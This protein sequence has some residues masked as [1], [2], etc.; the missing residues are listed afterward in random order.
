MRFL[1]ERG[2]DVPIIRTFAGG[3][4]FFVFW[5]VTRVVMILPDTRARRTALDACRG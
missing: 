2:L 3:F 4:V 5:G 1:G